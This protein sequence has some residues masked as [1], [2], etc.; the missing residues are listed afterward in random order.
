MN[1]YPIVDPY[2]IHYDTFAGDVYTLDTASI[3]LTAGTM[4]AAAMAKITNTTR[5]STKVN[6]DNRLLLLRRS[7]D[8]VEGLHQS[9]E[10]HGYRCGNLHRVLLHGLTESLKSALGLL[11]CLVRAAGVALEPDLGFEICHASPASCTSG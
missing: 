5:I 11:D 4:T 7:G 2:A 9:V 8:R 3:T 6:P 1:I 10:A